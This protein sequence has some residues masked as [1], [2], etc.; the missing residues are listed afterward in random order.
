MYEIDKEL[1]IEEMCQRLIDYLNVVGSDP[2]TLMIRAI[3]IASIQLDHAKYEVGAVDKERRMMKRLMVSDAE[4]EII[5]ILIAKKRRAKRL[6]LALDR[7]VEMYQAGE[8][9]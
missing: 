5:A 8:I 9:R 2:D 6:G 1:T 7:L 3:N 4:S